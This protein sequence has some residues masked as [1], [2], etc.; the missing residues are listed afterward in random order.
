MKRGL[1]KLEF[2]SELNESCTEQCTFIYYFMS[3]TC[4][5]AINLE[6]PTSCVVPKAII[7]C[8]NAINLEGPEVSKSNYRW[9]AIS[10]EC[11]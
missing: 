9:R 4:E 7:Y 5:K 3:S 10:M 8:E 1:M 2:W 6:G 11:G